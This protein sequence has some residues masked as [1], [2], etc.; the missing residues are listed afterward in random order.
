MRMKS[1]LGLLV[2]QMMVASQMDD[3]FYTQ[4]RH[5]PKQSPNS[6]KPKINTP[7]RELREFRV[8]G[9]TV[10]AYSKKDAIK[11]MNHKKQK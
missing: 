4:N 7:K 5:I 11:R 8:K 1:I 6:Q 2:A 9:K 3:V 10:M